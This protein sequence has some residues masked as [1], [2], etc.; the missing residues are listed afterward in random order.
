MGPLQERDPLGNLLR[1]E[2]IW[3]PC[4]FYF[5]YYEFCAT[6]PC[7]PVRTYLIYGKKFRF[8]WSWDI[9]LHGLLGT[10]LT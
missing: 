7:H 3:P 9:Q 6:I 1:G 10:K 2:A 5:L 4:P 8:A